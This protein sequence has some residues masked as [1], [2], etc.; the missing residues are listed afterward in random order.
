MALAERPLS[1]GPTIFLETFGCQMNQL[2][3]ELVHGQLTLLG[4]T[5]TSDAS[6]ADVVLYNTCSVRAQAEN[7]VLSRLGRLRERKEQ[8]SRVIVGVIGCMAEREGRQLLDKYPQIDLL[9]GPSE[10]DK[11]PMLLDNALKTE[12]VEEADRVAL[13]SAGSR[14]ASAL[15]A[16]P[17]NLELLDLSRVFDPT[18]AG[19]GASAYVRI[20]RGCNKFCTYCVVPFTRGPE[21]NR[22]PDHIVEECRRL[23]AAGAVEITLLGQTVNHYAYTHGP[24]VTVGGVEA[25][26]IGPGS[27]GDRRRGGNRRLGRVTAFADL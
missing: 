10:L 11:L 26:Q 15:A 3:S 25:A 5:F 1:L 21:V 12:A 22:P 27:F 20:T 7:K 19:G 23:G 8:G 16:A 2:D 6:A 18:R 14:R 4:Y 13:R 9:C 17:D 24:A